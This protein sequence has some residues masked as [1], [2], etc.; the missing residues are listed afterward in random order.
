MAWGKH[1]T[2]WEV[3]PQVQVVNQSHV[4][5]EYPPAT[6]I[7]L[8]WVISALGLRA[9]Y[10]LDFLAGSP[11]GEIAILCSWIVLFFYVMTTDVLLVLVPSR[12]SEV[13]DQTLCSIPG[14]LPTVPPQE[15]G[16]FITMLRIYHMAN[17]QD[18][19]LLH[20]ISVQELISLWFSLELPLP[21]PPGSP[22][23]LAQSW[24]GVLQENLKKQC[25]VRA[26]CLKL[27][28]PSRGH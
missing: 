28:E 24:P 26:S 6:I 17:V 1:P 15:L 12:P 2:L 7:H 5:E 9:G 19:F 25:W 8:V 22:A 18:G 27:R 4:W 11:Y 10:K 21:S 20:A 3:T 14:Y 13:W 16:H 23:G